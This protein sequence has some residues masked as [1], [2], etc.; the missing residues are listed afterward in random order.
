MKRLFLFAGYD[1]DGIVDDSLLWY[2]KSL[3]GLGD[4][5]FVMDNDATDV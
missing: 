5:V 1:R 4:I 3:S 2:L